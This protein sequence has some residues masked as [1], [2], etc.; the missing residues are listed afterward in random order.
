MNRPRMALKKPSESLITPPVERK[1]TID[2]EED[3]RNLNAD[4][5]LE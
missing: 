3:G 2:D 5:E 1:S 4:L